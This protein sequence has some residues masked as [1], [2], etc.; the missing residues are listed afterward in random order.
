VFLR[1]VNHPG[2]KPRKFSEA[3]NKDAI[4][5]LNKEVKNGYRRGLRKAAKG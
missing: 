3:I 1:K 2:F 4:P 5:V